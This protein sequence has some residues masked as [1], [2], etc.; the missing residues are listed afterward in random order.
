MGLGIL[1]FITKYLMTVDF[2]EITYAEFK[3]S[4]QHPYTFS[5]L[6]MNICRE[7][8]IISFI[9][10]NENLNKTLDYSC[11]ANTRPPDTSY[12]CHPRPDMAA[13]INE[14]NRNA[15]NNS[16]RK[17]LLTPI[18]SEDTNDNENMELCNRKNQ[19]FELV[20]DLHLLVN[21]CTGS[22]DE[23]GGQLLFHRIG[24]RYVPNYRCV[25]PNSLSLFTIVSME[26][27]C[28]LKM[29][30]QILLLLNQLILT[31][32]LA[33]DRNVSQEFIVQLKIYSFNIVNISG[34]INKWLGMHGA[35]DYAGSNTRKAFLINNAVQLT[36][37]SYY[38]LENVRELIKKIQLF[39]EC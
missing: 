39:V 12:S 18:I 33:K 27:T 15:Q 35:P 9:E 10:I 17:Q 29:H 3:T 5:D 20:R 26:K 22:M 36:S 13:I 7:K 14:K 21:S 8:N 6:H 24:N 4:C 31:G 32:N 2:L 1:D 23:S 28:M 30:N 16:R 19:T 38:L 11:P 37:F 34:E 25:L